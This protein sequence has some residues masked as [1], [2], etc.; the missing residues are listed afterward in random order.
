MQVNIYRVLLTKGVTTYNSPDFALA[1]AIS[2]YPEINFTNQGVLNETIAKFIYLE[3]WRVLQRYIH[4]IYLSRIEI[5][6][7]QRCGFTNTEYRI[8]FDH[9]PNLE[10]KLLNIWSGDVKFISETEVDKTDK[11]FVA[12]TVIQTCG[13]NNPWY[14]VVKPML[15]KYCSSDIIDSFKRGLTAS[16]IDYQVAEREH[17]LEQNLGA[18]IFLFEQICQAVYANLPKS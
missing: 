14:L 9:P 7:V 13:T 11:A 4:S 8:Y 5:V 6:N 17:G 2:T 15:V 16:N 18:P 1:L 10:N 12:G 3:D